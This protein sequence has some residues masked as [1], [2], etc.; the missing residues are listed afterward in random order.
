MTRKTTFALATALVA[1]ASAFVFIGARR[2]DDTSALP[3]SS[4]AF[5]RDGL[6]V[7]WWRSADA[8]SSWRAPL[9]ALVN[10]VRWHDENAPVS[11][12]ELSLEGTG[13]AKHTG[14]I[15]AR[16]DPARA[17]L[18][19]DAVASEGL[20]PIGAEWSLPAAPPNALL[21]VNAG[22][23][24]VGGAWGWVVRGGREYQIPRSAPLAPAIVVDAGGRVSI[25]AP[26]SIDS[27]ARTGRVAEAFQSYPM[28]LV[29]GEVPAPLQ[30]A[31]GGIDLAHRDARL[32]LGVLGDGR[33]LIALTR[34]EGLG[35]TLQLLP[36]GLTTPEMAA[37]MGALGCRDAVL[38]DGG[39]S[40]Q[41]AVRDAAGEVYRWAGLRRVP[42]G[43][44]ALP[45]ANREGAR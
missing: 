10:A 40:G 33:I 7:E 41:L 38:L 16:I 23:F 12:G 3:P 14:V 31:G 27:A 34:F 21:A 29:R 35:G 9:P 2:G 42:L 8:P 4:L 32:A 20:A 13:E 26:G 25:V 11:W 28:L 17:S 39:V 22:Q 18:K 37:L 30:R 43:L 1:A 5:V 45:A 19:L 36:L 24:N 6:T 15:L 44:V